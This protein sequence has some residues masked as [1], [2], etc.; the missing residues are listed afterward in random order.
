MPNAYDESLNCE[1]NRRS[2]DAIHARKYGIDA[3]NAIQNPSSAAPR[4][5]LLLGGFSVGDVCLRARTAFIPAASDRAPEVS[6]LRV[7]N[8]E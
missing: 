5:R 8:E 2:S 7:K 4:M 3:V 1:Q 6:A